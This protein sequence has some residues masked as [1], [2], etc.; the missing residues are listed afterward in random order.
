MTEIPKRVTLRENGNYIWSAELD[1]DSERKNYR[2]GGR[3]CGILAFVIL[4]VGAVVA[5]LYHSWRVFL[6]FAGTA[7][8]TVLITFGVVHGQENMGQICCTYRLMDELIATGSGRRTALFEFKK[9][10]Q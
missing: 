8:I 10:R 7:L 6:F 2:T 9:R 4:F 3:L 1:M 5:G